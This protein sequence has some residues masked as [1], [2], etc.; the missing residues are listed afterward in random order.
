MQ[1]VIAGVS[2]MK[3][4]SMCARRRPGRS[5]NFSVPSTEVFALH[6]RRRGEA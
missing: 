1:K 2:G 6:Q 4:D 3:T 5:R